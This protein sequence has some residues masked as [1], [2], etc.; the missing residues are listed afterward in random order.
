MPVSTP[1]PAPEA[2]AQ[3]LHHPRLA[4]A[5]SLGMAAI[6][7]LALVAATRQ[8]L[9]HPGDF[10]LVFA[11]I[12]ALIGAVPLPAYGSKVSLSP[13]PIIA[14]AFI[15]GPLAAAAVGFAA[16]IGAE[17]RAHSHGWRCPYN[18]GAFI[19]SGL[20][21]GLAGHA[22]RSASGTSPLYLLT[23]GLLTAGA[24]YLTNI[25]PL[26]LVVTAS[27]GGSPLGVW[28]ERFR[29]MLPQT[30]L[31]G[32]VG[33]G[34]AVAYRYAGVYELLAFALPIVAMHVAWRQYLAHTTRSV[35]DLR[36]KNADLIHLAARLQSANDQVNVAYRGTLEALVGALDAR[37]NEVQGH[38][39]RVSAYSQILAERLGIEHGSLEWETIARGA[40]LHDVGKIG[41][42]DAVL[43]KPGALDDAEW[44]EMR[45]HAKIGFGILRGIEFLQPA[46]ALVQAHHE[47]FDCQGYPH[48][49]KGEEI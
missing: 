41:I 45:T 49:L 37:D 23:F 5:L 16:A 29:W 48:G 8:Y 47:R 27:A 36:Q 17:S 1:A 20:L 39:Y 31:L 7:A 34:V 26:C 9:A 35:E 38:S 13:L 10:P 24:L 15:G 14:A 42:R 3:G 44:A 46:A 11:A 25:V 2:A 19:V 33:T 43:Q 4:A 40:L 30:L 18:A 32:P 6:G 12:G 22:L 21:G 28:R